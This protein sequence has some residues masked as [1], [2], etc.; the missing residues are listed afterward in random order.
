MVEESRQVENQ[1]IAIA[2]TAGVDMT[3][4]QPP[5]D[6]IGLI[7]S[8][9]YTPDM[10]RALDH[11]PELGLGG[12]GAAAAYILGMLGWQVQLNSPVGQ[13]AAGNM[14]RE[15]LREANVESIAPKSNATMFSIVPV[16]SDAK[17]LGVLHFASPKVDWNFSAQATTASWFLLAGHSKVETGELDEVQQ[18]LKLFRSRGGITVLDS[19]I[20]WMQTNPA[21]QMATVW[22]HVDLLIGTMDELMFWTGADATKQV[23][24]RAQQLG[25]RRVVVKMGADGAALLDENGQFE[26]QPAKRVTRSDVSIGAG[27]AFNGA[28]VAQLMAGHELN[29]AVDFAQTVAAKVVTTGNGV[30]GWTP[31]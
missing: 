2:G 26:H 7:R 16:D 9:N 13:D 5:L 19:G 11:P 17:R 14:V 18:A 28:L 20:G 30:I 31:S 1:T 15:W 27:D 23:A 3:L 10:I 4:R 29:T 12:N 8:D 25:A 22:S 24:Q 21:D 6:E